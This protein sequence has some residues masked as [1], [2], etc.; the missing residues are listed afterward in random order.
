MKKKSTQTDLKNLFKSKFEESIWEILN[1]EFKNCKYELD[2]YE[3]TQPAI[4]RT[5]TPDFKTGSKKIYL[6]TKG[7]LDL[8]TRQKMVWFKE[9]NPAIRIIFLFQNANVKI[10]KGSKT[11]YGDWATKNG[12]EWLDSKGDWLNAYKE[13]LKN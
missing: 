12:F 8:E 6:E 7:K 3:Y 4:K 2:S 13:M 5:Y 11:S 9:C 10:R 1:K